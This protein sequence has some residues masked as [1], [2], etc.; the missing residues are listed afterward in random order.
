[1]FRVIPLFAVVLAVYNVLL[2]TSDMPAALA[3]PVLSIGLVSGATWVLDLGDAL[4]A[5]GIVVLYVEVAKA[6][7]T[8]TVS[9]LDHTLSL[10]VFIGFVVQFITVAG[11]GTSTFALLGL[12][13]LVDVMAG[14]TVTIV[15]ARRDFGVGDRL[16]H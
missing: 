15:G 13:S 2:A 6:T 12:M 10:L 14:F 1:M 9:V 16:D 8:S 3:G 11:A 4:L 5:F 7:R